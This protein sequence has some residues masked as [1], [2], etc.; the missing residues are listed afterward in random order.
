MIFHITQ[1]Y[2]SPG[3]LKQKLIDEQLSPIFAINKTK[4][5]VYNQYKVQYELLCLLL[6]RCLINSLK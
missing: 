4:T 2:P 3:F 1:D 5:H 6:K